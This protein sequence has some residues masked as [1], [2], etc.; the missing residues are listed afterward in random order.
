M[1]DNP[2]NPEEYVREVVDDFYDDLGERIDHEF[3]E[4]DR[5]EQA[6]WLYNLKGYDEQVS[7]DES[8]DMLPTREEFEDEFEPEKLFP[9]EY[10][11]S[12][13]H[14]AN[15]PKWVVGV[16]VLS[17]VVYAA[18]PTLAITSLGWYYTN[19]EWFPT[20]A[21]PNG[22]VIYLAT[23]AAISI[24]VIGLGF[25]LWAALSWLTGALVYKP[26]RDEMRDAWR[27]GME[28]AS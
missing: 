7:A 15:L 26:L 17:R 27:E 2:D 3:T 5:V 13:T 16:I 8:L 14:G 18:I 24:V 25:Y 4:M 12:Q 23:V 1:K 11:D 22:V 21:D 19:G 10:S 6:N 20:V 9:E 28:E